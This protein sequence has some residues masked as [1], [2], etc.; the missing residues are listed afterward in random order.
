MLDTQFKIETP[1][2]IELGIRIA[3]PIV[4]G[5]A[6]LIDSVI[7][8]LIYLAIYLII[9]FS[10]VS[11]GESGF[12]I[13]LG[14]LLI[15][16]FL[17]EWFYS[18]LFE[19]YANGATPGKKIMGIKVVCDSGVP[20]NWSSSLTRNIVRIVDM[21]PFL[22]FFPTCGLGLL[23]ILFGKRFKRIGDIAAGTV[24]VY[25]K[26][27]VSTSRIKDVEPDIPQQHLTLEEKK[28][29]VMF[30][31]RHNIMTDSRAAELAD[32]LQVLTE[33]TGKNGVH[34]LHGYASWVIGEK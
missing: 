34:K 15:I 2:G 23:F 7:K 11:F 29:I 18:V 20:I 27:S 24:V 32:I 26:D 9:I 3:G 17:F 12:N 33:E 19:I 30:S 25:S 4:R 22:Y 1:E 8:V 28:S 5:I 13:A 21:F 16:I 14:L 10:Y 6:F 31:E